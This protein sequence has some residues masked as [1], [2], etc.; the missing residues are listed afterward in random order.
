MNEISRYFPDLTAGQTEQFEALPA[1][2]RDWN[3]KINVISRRDT[4]EIVLHHILHSLAIARFLKANPSVSVPA[5]ILDLGTGGG[6]PGVP[7]A[8]AMPEAR[9]TLIDGTAKKIHVCQAV[10]EALGLK[11]CRA[12]WRRGEQETGRYDYVVSRAVMPMADLARLVKPVMRKA[13]PKRQPLPYPAGLIAL[14]GG[15]LTEELKP[16]HGAAITTPINAYFQETWFDDKYVVY[17]PA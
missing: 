8:I 13:G 15:D 5:D 17:L 3:A 1:L 10:I 16:L 2:Y 9:F 4:D 11:N 7:L 14:K 6:F 12:F